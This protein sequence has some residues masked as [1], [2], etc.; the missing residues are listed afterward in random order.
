MAVEVVR[1]KKGSSLPQFNAAMD[2]F[3]SHMPC[4]A[5]KLRRVYLRLALQYHPDKS[6]EKDRT[7]ATQLFQAIAAA[8]EGLLESLQE[9][10]ASAGMKAR[11]KSPVAAAAELGDV[12]EL[13]R[14]LQECPARANEKD[15][16]GV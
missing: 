13:R 14:L 7:L 15:D 8:Y 2:L 12:E 3:S 11:V 10:G 4:D 6:L 5:A 9:D 1:G 16:L